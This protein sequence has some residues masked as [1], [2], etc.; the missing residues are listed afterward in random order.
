MLGWLGG[1]LGV[2]YLLAT[3]NAWEKSLLLSKLEGLTSTAAL[4]FTVILLSTVAQPLL[5]ECSHKNEHR[6]PNSLTSKLPQQP[7]IRLIDIYTASW[8]EVDAKI[9]SQIIGALIDSPN[10]S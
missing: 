1:C 7:S 3:E 10:L 5:P 4:N 8:K 9:K 2:P 6:T